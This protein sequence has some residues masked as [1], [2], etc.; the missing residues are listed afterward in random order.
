MEKMHLTKKETDLL[1]PWAKMYKEAIDNGDDLFFGCNFEIYVDNPGTYVFELFEVSPFNEKS[2]KGIISS[3]DKKGAIE[4]GPVKTKADKASG[5]EHR[6][7]NFN[8]DVLTQIAND[9]KENDMNI[10]DIVEPVD[11]VSIEEVMDKATEE[12]V[13]E[14]KRS[15][16]ELFPEPKIGELRENPFKTIKIL[17]QNEKTGKWQYEIIKGASS[18]RTRYSANTNSIRTYW[19]PVED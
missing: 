5:D 7:F 4:L 13:K 11:T 10:E 8:P 19:K 17:A 12:F 2:T 3:L 1:K 14:T 9:T 18:K 6:E 16:K 15:K